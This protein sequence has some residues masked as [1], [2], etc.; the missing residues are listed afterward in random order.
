MLLQRFYATV[1]SPPPSR[2]LLQR[3]FAVSPRKR[4][5]QFFYE[6]RL[7]IPFSL[8]LFVFWVLPEGTLFNSLPK[9][10][11]NRPPVVFF[12]AISP[13]RAPFTSYH[14]QYSHPS[15]KTLD[16]NLFPLCA[17]SIQPSNLSY[18]DIQ[19]ATGHPALSKFPSHHAP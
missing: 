7:F 13:H 1:E 3:V 5:I 14:F 19:S 12:P 10:W 11:K 15:R 8:G 16:P 17:H 18:E 2:R 4:T 9:L 6:G